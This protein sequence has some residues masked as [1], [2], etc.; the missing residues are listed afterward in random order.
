M[1]VPSVAVTDT[2][3]DE[4]DSS[5]ASTSVLRLSDTLIGET[6]PPC[7][8]FERAD[9]WRERGPIHLGDAGNRFWLLTEMAGIRAAFH[10]PQVFSNTAIHGCAT[11]PHH[12]LHL[13]I[14]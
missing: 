11:T 9:Q 10:E 14:L 3:S 12:N 5:A 2:S 4:R 7:S 8:F 13:S 1:E 6:S